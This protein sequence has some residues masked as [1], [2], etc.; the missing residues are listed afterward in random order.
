MSAACVWATYMGDIEHFPFLFP[1]GHLDRGIVQI[2]T[3]HQFKPS[4][5]DH[6]P[7]NVANLQPDPP[8]PFLDS[9]A[10]R[11]GTPLE[12]PQ[13]GFVATSLEVKETSWENV[14]QTLQDVRSRAKNNDFP[15]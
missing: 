3:Q 6:L 12:R 1:G 4:M 5:V 10:F 8:R 14:M 13:N 7:I 15:P 11:Q 9:S 2:F